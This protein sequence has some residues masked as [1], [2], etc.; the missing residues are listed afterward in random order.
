MRLGSRRRERVKKPTFLELF[1]FV[2]T[3]GMA[4]GYEL[5]AVGCGLWAVGCG[6]GAWDAGRGMRGLDRQS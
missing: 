5:R 1:S 4:V 6:R 2:K 3:E